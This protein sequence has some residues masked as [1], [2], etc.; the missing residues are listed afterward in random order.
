[1]PR[2]PD[3]RAVLA[4][5]NPDA[6]LAERHLWLI[7]LFDWIRGDRRAPEAAVSRV[8]LFL[9]A[10][11]A[12]PELQARLSAWWQ[13][14]SR[15]VD[16]TTL[17]A[18]F[19]FAP[20]T[21]FVSELS[22]RL[23]RKLL[24]GTPETHDAAELFRLVL[25][26]DFD[27]RWLA[28]LDD[29][30]LDRLAAILSGGR[31]DSAARWQFIVLEAITYCTS[32]VIATGYAPE[33]RLRMDANRPAADLAAMNPA[34]SGIAVG[35]SSRD[36]TRL[37]RTAPDPVKQAEPFHALAESLQR[38]RAQVSNA[39]SVPAG[40][41][42][43]SRAHGVEGLLQA[44]PDSTEREEAALQ[45]ALQDFRERLDACR[46]AAS[47]VYA[48]LEEHGIS[49]GLVFR[50]RQLRE[51]VLRI[52]ELMDCLASPSPA[53]S[54]ARLISRLVAAGR[55]GASVRALIASNSSLLAAKV[56]ERS[57]ETGEHYIT[58]N[59]AEYTSMLR[60]A[61]GGGAMMSLTV[62]VKFALL[63]LG[64]SAFWGGFFAG[65]NF[66]ASFVAIQLLHL[67]VATKQP[68]MTA[69]AMAA[70]L[71]DL[72]QKDGVE[73]FVD[74]VAHLVRSQVAA[75]LGNVVVV[76]PCVLLISTIIMLITGHT[77][78]DKAEAAH[79]LHSLSILGP[80]LLFAA[81]T[82]VVLFASSIV[83]GWMEN[84][85]VLH[86]LDSAMRYNPRITAVLGTARANRW[87]TFM[88]DNI[89]GLASNISLGFMLGL[90]PAFAL[91]FGL[92]L[93]L[94]H[95]TLSTGQIAAAAAAYGL[96]MLTD[97][98]LLLPLLLC[99][100]GA[101]VTGM[102]N[103]GVSFYFA[104]RLAL[105]AHNASGTDRARIRSAIWA[106]WR[107]RPLSFFWPV[108]SDAAPS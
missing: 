64:L 90:I 94:R 34:S 73:S 22:E 103:V 47:S 14:L 62:L 108:R 104:F 36:Q 9:D 31:A 43:P 81:F 56:A 60:K 67:T 80:T 19:G 27:A 52:R 78:I 92:G 89:S 21:A 61:S 16:I 11:A 15:T 97:P 101:I 39:F 18:D 32:Q 58:R 99:A 35:D 54:A 29:E 65:V 107:S 41:P 45:A 40:M 1:M 6:P 63:G 3:L 88:R 86:N 71:K 49:V 66:A 46:Q 26:G 57:A 91:F 68:A 13:V 20:R 48:H 79:V 42:V 8:R 25:P 93:E 28:L 75:V 50:V 85:F 82:G 55:E 7:G 4:R 70:R 24:P 69:P 76:V 77:L 74:Q 23:R 96:P 72:N 10:V 87:A 5:L 38:L 33:L 59:N 105:R 12:Q 53:R 102:L 106:R 37:E 51:R 2:S 100:A 17:L 84:W 44:Q 30:M 95:V 98:S 83:A